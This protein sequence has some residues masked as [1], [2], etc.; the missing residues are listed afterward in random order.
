MAYD[1]SRDKK[2]T[3]STFSVSEEVVVNRLG[4]KVMVKGRDGTFTESDT[5]E[6]NLLFEIL[7]ALRKK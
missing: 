3:F 7:R 6:A 2:P 5:V 4:K 1:W